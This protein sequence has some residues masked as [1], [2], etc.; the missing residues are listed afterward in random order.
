MIFTKSCEIGAAAFDVT[1]ADV[2]D[3]NIPCLRHWRGN[4]G[5]EETFVI[6]GRR[7][8]ADCELLTN[9]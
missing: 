6:L 7:T 1:A 5:A 9:G 4:L 2:L 8:S 3:S